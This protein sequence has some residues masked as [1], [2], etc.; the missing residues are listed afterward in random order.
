MR[1]DTKKHDFKKIEDN[2]SKGS[3][4]DVYKCNS[5]GQIQK[6]YIR[7]EEEMNEYFN[8]YYAE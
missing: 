8:K 4:K 1:N 5:C 6:M 3:Q 7:T 2:L